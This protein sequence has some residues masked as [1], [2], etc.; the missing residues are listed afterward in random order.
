MSFD[1]QGVRVVYPGRGGPVQALDGVTYS[2]RNPIAVKGIA[3]PV[4]HVRVVA[5]GP[6]V[7]RGFRDLGLTR[8]APLPQASRGRRPRCGSNAKG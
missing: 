4:R 6:D 5:D 1:L 8:A 7:A 3:Q 2:A